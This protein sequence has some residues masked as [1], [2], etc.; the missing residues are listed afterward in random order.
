MAKREKTIVPISIIIIT[1]NEEKALP[2][3]LKTIKSQDCQPLEIIVADSKSTDNTRKIAKSF[4]CRIVPG[5]RPSAGRNSG[6]SYAKGEWLLFLDADVLLPKGFIKKTYTQLQ[7]SKIDTATVWFRPDTRKIPSE[8]LMIIY[9]SYQ[10]STQRVWPHAIGACIFCKKTLFDKIKG[11][12]VKVTLAEDMDFVRRAA[13]KGKFQVLRAYVFYS[14]RRYLEEGKLTMAKKIILTELY[15][16]I[17]GEVRSKKVQDK[18]IKYYDRG[19]WL[20][21]MAEAR[22]PKNK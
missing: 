2:K 9:N 16:A 1:L 21:K 12:D 11:F 10:F 20:K 18:L 3:L 22:A 5:G 17:R 6:A 15:R 13:K 4:G 19:D 7:N 8:M 14:M